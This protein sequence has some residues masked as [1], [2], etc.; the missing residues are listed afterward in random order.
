MLILLLAAAPLA[1]AQEGPKKPDAPEPDSNIV[2]RKVD[3]LVLAL[4]GSEAERTV[5]EGELPRRGKAA[6]PPLVTC[7][8]AA[9]G[10]LASRLAAARILHKLKEPSSAAALL[11]VYKDGRVPL[12]VRGETALAL[13]DIK[14]AEAVPDLIDGLADNMFKV[15]ETARAALVRMGD[16][17]IDGVIDA[18]KKENGA[19]EPRDGIIFRSLLILGDIGGDKARAALCA[20]L[21]THDG[22]RAIG[23]R[24][25]AALAIGIMQDKLAIDELLE[26]YET[27]RDLRVAGSIERSLEWLTGEHG[28][29]PQP[30]RWK[31]W[32]GIHRDQILG[33][34]DHAHDNILLPK[35]GIEKGDPLDGTPTSPPKSDPPKK[36]E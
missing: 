10:S 19:K 4:S 18:Y 24:H 26:A 28:L 34:G 12:D 8:Q 13:G 6:V 32:W 25:H 20:A 30:Y 11:Q 31:A 35:G 15:S 21:K 14:A 36:A 23:I 9:E 5:A 27:E 29:P 3:E 7:L 16:L 2:N 1:S 22:P 17:A 33:K